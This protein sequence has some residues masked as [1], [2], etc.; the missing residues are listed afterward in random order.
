MG[1]LLTLEAGA[2]AEPP[3]A[4]KVVPAPPGDVM[5][6]DAG[7]V[8]DLGVGLC[9]GV[10]VDLVVWVPAGVEILPAVVTAGTGKPEQSV[11]KSSP[12]GR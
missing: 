3:L 4:G 7:L 10:V 12:E 1:V 9:D 6:V 11:S 5:G 2:V 8:L